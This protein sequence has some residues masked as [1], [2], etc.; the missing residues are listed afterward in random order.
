MAR[1]IEKVGMPPDEAVMPPEARRIRTMFS[2]INGEMVRRLTERY[3]SAVPPER[4]Q[5]LRLPILFEERPE[6]D[7]AFK[8]APGES[9]HSGTVLGFVVENSWE[10][11]HVALDQNREQLVVS[12][13]H[14]RI[15]QIADPSAKSAMGDSFYEGVTEHMARDIAGP[16]GQSHCYDREVSAVENVERKVGR[17]VVENAY[18]K[19]D[20]VT[21]RAKVDEAM[22]IG[23]LGKFGAEVK[24]WDDLRDTAY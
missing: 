22:G 13:I 8:K 20:M 2:D 6:F 24:K 21:L 4:L 5:K 3:G 11:P 1:G 15:H 23:S 14:E 12:G 7:R 10:S 17:D 16:D 18:L 9:P 19:G